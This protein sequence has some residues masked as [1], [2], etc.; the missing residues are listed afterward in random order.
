MCE[1]CVYASGDSATRGKC[2]I[3]GII[4]LERIGLDDGTIPPSSYLFI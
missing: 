3:K 1:Q 4:G 2:S